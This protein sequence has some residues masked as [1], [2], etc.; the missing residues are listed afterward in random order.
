MRKE[1]TDGI[2]NHRKKDGDCKVPAKHRYYYP[3]NHD[4][5]Q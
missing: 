2:Y 3:G 1:V 4:E 5:E